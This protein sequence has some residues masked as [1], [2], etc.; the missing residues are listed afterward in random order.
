M[1]IL[2]PYQ[3]VLRDA[4]YQEW[5]RGHKNV[6]MRLDTGGGKTKIFSEIIKDHPGSSVLIAHRQE[7]VS[8]ISVAL[9]RNGLRHN[10]IA[11]KSTRAAIARA[12]IEELGRTFYDPGS[13]C[14]VASVDTLV[15]AD[16]PPGWAETVT[17]WVVDEGHHLV[18]D[19]KWHTAIGRFTHPAVRGLLP[20][21]TPKRAD[22]KGLGRKAIGGNGVADVMVQ[23]PP[24][25]WLIDQG[26]LCDYRIICPPSDLQMLVDVAAS[27]D[28]SSKALREAAE[29]SHIIGDVVRAYQEFAAGKLCITF[30][31][32]VVTAGE[33]AAAFRQ[34]G[35]TA[36]VLTGKTDDGLRRSILRR[37]AQRE[38]MQLVVVDIVSEGFDLPAVEACI[39]ARPT[40]SLALYMQQ[41]GR[42]LRIMEGKG[43]AIVID[44]VANILRH[45][46]PPDKPRPWFLLR[47]ENSRSAAG[48][49]IPYR[50]CLACYEPYERFYKDCPHCGHHPEPADRRS[51]KAVDGALSELDADVLEMLR[52]PVEA[53]DAHE[54]FYRQEL[55][56]TGLPH[57][58]IVSNVNRRRDDQEAQTELRAV[59][60]GF[61]GTHHARGLD[62]TAI[63]KLF[64]LRFGLDVMSAMALKAKDARALAIKING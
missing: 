19:N 32:D 25:R 43:K 49:G 9:A 47:A 48:D 13:R 40:A 15:K 8:Q 33:Q 7:L 56:Q 10:L 23:G 24:M 58:F 22:G 62:D 4:V 17:L 41:F 20:T 44:L 64:Y 2:R 31:T 30:S 6:L 34:A 26:Y 59:M 54:D 50:I 27:G 28:W 29:R 60:A 1:T 46:G 53:L 36:E 52:K 21:A 12:H 18:E 35:I 11:A 14:V 37:F 55:I 3:S 61:G 42:V 38:I 57:A 63:Q 5:E 45:Q 51:P 39:M 16:L